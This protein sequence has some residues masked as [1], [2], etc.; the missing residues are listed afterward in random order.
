M[1]LVGVT[2]SMILIFFT[3]SSM[4]WAAP[5]YAQFFNSI[6]TSTMAGGFQ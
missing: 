2:G 6:V 1:F 3:E 5:S 4:G